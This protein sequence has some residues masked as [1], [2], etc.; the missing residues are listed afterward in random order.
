M[1]RCNVTAALCLFSACGLADSVG[2]IYV[3]HDENGTPRFA[4]QPYSSDYT[5]YSR[6]I[7]SSRSHAPRKSAASEQLSAIAP[8]IEQAA[9]KHGVD[10]ALVTA[11]ADVESGFNSRAVSPR[12]AMGVMQLVSSTATDYGVNDP[13]DVQ[14]NIDGGTRY[15]KDL[16]DAHHG[17]IALALAA[18]NAGKGR[19]AK[20]HQRIPPISETMLYVPQVLAK[21]AAYKRHPERLSP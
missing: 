10:V 15:L 20:N 21:M 19:V 5:L 18:Y 14:Q 8:Y 7:P 9:R 17:N 16:I 13:Y 4:T 2:T 3:A 12:G 1:R 6:P 11:V